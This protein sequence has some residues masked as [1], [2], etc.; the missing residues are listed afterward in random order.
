MRFSKICC[1]SLMCFRRQH[2]KQEA[3]LSDFMQR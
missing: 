3:E 1:T 2:K